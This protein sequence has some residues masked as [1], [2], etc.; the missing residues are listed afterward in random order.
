MPTIYVNSVAQYLE[1]YVPQ[2]V[3]NNLD[4]LESCT[5]ELLKPDGSLLVERPVAPSASARTVSYTTQA[6]ELD[7]PGRYELRAKFTCP[8]GRVWRSDP[9][10]FR[11]WPLDRQGT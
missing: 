8:G 5:G 10:A 4:S 11:V 1:L 3:V 7:Q 9:L 6:G 2:D